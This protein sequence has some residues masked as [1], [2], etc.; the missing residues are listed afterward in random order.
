MEKK[1]ARKETA[2]K[3][4]SEHTNNLITNGVVS[5]EP[6]SVESPSRM[7][8]VDQTRPMRDIERASAKSEEEE[9][10]MSVWMTFALLVVV[11]VVCSVL[12]WELIPFWAVC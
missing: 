1:K 12:P 9:P 2:E 7:S 8:T 6:E 11:T 3:E 5:T 4:E 10:Q